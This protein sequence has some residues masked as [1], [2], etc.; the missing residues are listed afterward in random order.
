MVDAAEPAILDLS[1]EVIELLTEIELDPS[2]TE[3]TLMHCRLQQIDSLLPLTRLE[4][5]NLRANRIREVQGLQNCVLLRELE[6][7]ENQITQLS[8]L[9]GLA[10]LELL[11]VSFN[12]LTRIDGLQ[13]LV[14]LREL[15][16]AN[17]KIGAIEGLH[18]L[19]ALRLL[20]L[21]SNRLRAIKLDH[22][23]SL[24]E[25]HL[26]RNKLTQLDGLQ[27][28]AKLRVLGVV[29]HRGGVGLRPG[30]MR[31]QHLL[32]T[33]SPLT[34]AV[35]SPLLAHYLPGEQP[36]ALLDGGRVAAPAKGAV[37]GP[38][39]AREHGAARRTHGAAHAGAKQQP[40]AGSGV[41]L[42]RVA[43]GAVAQRQP[44]RGGGTPR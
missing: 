28:L 15:Y 29:S 44:R 33:T 9:D 12:E 43:R 23:S 37:R 11:D 31:L 7:Y 38:Q 42:A 20:E 4:K 14:A 16:L 17:N 19:P 39:R 26:G 27:A 2:L 5:L 13:G 8:G 36:S 32:L 18:G 21:G 6:L 35:Y 3:L 25:L 34:I 41:R 24:E 1:G 22:L 40:A 30:D 10:R